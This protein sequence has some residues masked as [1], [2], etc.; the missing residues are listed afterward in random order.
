MKGSNIIRL[1]PGVYQLEEGCFEWDTDEAN[2]ALISV[3]GI[4]TELRANLSE[5]KITSC[6]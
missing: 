3:G 5:R 4:H 6:E 1:S 2:T